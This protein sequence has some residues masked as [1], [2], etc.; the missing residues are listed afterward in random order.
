MKKYHSVLYICSKSPYTNGKL[1]KG[2][3]LIESCI[4]QHFFQNFG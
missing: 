1:A 4:L 2:L 3:M